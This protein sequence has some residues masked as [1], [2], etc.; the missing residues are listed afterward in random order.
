VTNTPRLVC[1]PCSAPTKACNLW[2]LD[3]SVAVVPLGLNANQIET[4]SILTDDPVQ[5]AV[6]GLAS[7]GQQ[8]LAAPVT[9]RAEQSQAEPLQ[10]RR[11]LREH[12]VEQFRGHRVVGVR[13]EALDRFRGRQGGD[14]D[15]ARL[16]VRS[17]RLTLL[18]APGSEFQKLGE[19]LQDLVVHT[20]GVLV[21]HRAPPVGDDIHAAL[22][23][24]GKARLRHVGQRPADAA[25]KHGGLAARQHLRQVVPTDAGVGGHGVA[26]L[27]AGLRLAARQGSQRRAHQRLVVR[28]SHGRHLSGVRDARPRIRSSTTQAAPTRRVAALDAGYLS[29][30]GLRS[31][32]T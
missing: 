25:P 22:G 4:E 3:G 16:A 29:V 1:A 2:A 27:A 14:A 21:Q 12:P 15:R 32:T 7:V 17:D 13:N 28:D 18:V 9:H 5:A 31:N 11:R 30:S 20:L 26:D 24:G 23:P 8:S 19:L 10:K 6:T